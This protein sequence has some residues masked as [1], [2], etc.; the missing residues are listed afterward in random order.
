MRAR[1]GGEAGD[2]AWVSSN[3]N[4]A[5]TTITVL[6]GGRGGRGPHS[7]EA[8]TAAGVLRHDASMTSSLA[9][10]PPTPSPFFTKHTL[11]GHLGNGLVYA[12]AHAGSLGK[13]AGARVVVEEAHTVLQHPIGL[14]R[15]REGKARG[16]GAEGKVGIRQQ[17]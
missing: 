11:A 17:A 10:P 8:P 2:R 1:G 6:R 12:R 5:N 9:S 16:A 4:H 14:V 7:W 13:E 3:A 15:E